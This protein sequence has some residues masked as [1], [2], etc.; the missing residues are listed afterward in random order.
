MPV[1]ETLLMSENDKAASAVLNRRFPDIRNVAMSA[2]L[3]PS[4]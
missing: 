2:T 1:I 3:E 4:R